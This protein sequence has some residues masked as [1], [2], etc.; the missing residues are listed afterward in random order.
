M[1]RVLSLVLSG[2]LAVASVGCYS[3]PDT[4][5]QIG[6]VTGGLIG[7]GLGAVVGAQTGNPGAGVA[8]GS[9]AGA[10]AGGAV[11]NKI[12]AQES[13]YASNEERLQRQEQELGSTR[14]EIQGLRR[15]QDDTRGGAR[16]GGAEMRA[17]P[18][19]I[20]A[21]EDLSTSTRMR[22]AQMAAEGKVVDPFAGKSGSAAY[23]AGDAQGDDEQAR[24]GLKL[25]KRGKT[26]FEGN[27]GAGGDRK[28]VG[29]TKND[30]VA[31]AGKLGKRE[32]R[33]AAAG[34]A[35]LD[36]QGD[37]Q[38]GRQGD[39][40][41]NA[42]DEM[43][44]EVPEAG[45]ERDSFLAAK[46]AEDLE[47]KGSVK[48]KEEELSGVRGKVKDS[49]SAVEALGDAGQDNGLVR[50]SS[51][52][53]PLVP[54]ASKTGEQGRAAAAE[55]DSFRWGNGAAESADK[56]R[57]DFRVD[58]EVLEDKQRGAV[59]K[60]AGSAKG[61]AGSG[62][63]LPSVSEETLG[64]LLD[65]D[66]V[67][68]KAGSRSSASNGVGADD[69][70]IAGN[71]KKI[72][73]ITSKGFVEKTLEEVDLVK[74]DLNKVGGEIAATGS[75]VAGEINQGISEQPDA[76]AKLAKS[77]ANAANE[78]ARYGEESTLGDLSELEGDIDQLANSVGETDGGVDQSAQRLVDAKGADT[79][80]PCG[81]AAAD[82]KEGMAVSSH[83]DKLF[84]YRRAIR[85]CPTDP[86][87]HNAL[88][89][90]YQSLKRY[91]DAKHEFKEA[92]AVEPSYSKSQ[93]NLRELD[94]L[95]SGQ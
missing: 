87:Y 54:S 5:T 85:L 80:S 78:L 64:E 51:I 7:A 70:A 30:K 21:K 84:H 20:I 69:A 15:N 74:G 66:Q 62:P 91:D 95:K 53:S 50:P 57:D 52:F 16:V 19:R 86:K 32:K 55:N 77:R 58:H 79:K 22:L 8:I 71:G 1:R 6:A 68:A 82:L 83:G 56:G 11:G 18:G 48:E 46:A 12:D 33:G 3:D 61:A 59:K 89:E 44:E 29:A 42:V 27:L 67:E 94:K 49:G 37:R 39:L 75:A 72:E 28:S 36:R 76:A 4:N 2:A 31:K 88:G 14:R 63:A 41:G 25:S 60:I 47:S 90:F 38:G 35:K 81:Q 43:V 24:A 65:K 26:A 93:Q 10:L 40:Q 92:L 23:L 17:R 73:S 9:V 13:R 34:E 45:G